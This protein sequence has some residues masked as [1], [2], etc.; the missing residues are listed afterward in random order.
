[1]DREEAWPFAERRSRSSGA[2]PSRARAAGR[3]RRRRA[4]SRRTGATKSTRSRARRSALRSTGRVVR[5]SASAPLVQAVRR[6]ALVHALDLRRKPRDAQ[7]A[8]QPRAVR[9]RRASRTGTRLVLSRRRGVRRGGAPA[10]RVRSSTAARRPQGAR[11]SSRGSNEIGD[12]GAPRWATPSRAARRPYARL[13]SATRGGATWANALARGA[14]PAASGSKFDNGRERRPV[15]HVGA[16]EPRP[17]RAT[18]SR[19]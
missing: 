18:R 3:A 2:A 15:S 17:E 6:R 19:A 5:R 13:A 9:E 8:V 12:E 1:M 11:E 14:G 10:R 7:Q 4:A 16:Q